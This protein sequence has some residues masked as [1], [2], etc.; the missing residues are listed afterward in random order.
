MKNIDA[1]KALLARGYDGRMPDTGLAGRAP[2]L[3]WTAALMVPVAAASATLLAA[4][5]AL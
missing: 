1:Q 4:G 5:G 2:A 3:G